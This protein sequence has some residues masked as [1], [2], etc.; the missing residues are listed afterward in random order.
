MIPTAITA[1]LGGPLDAEN[2]CGL[3]IKFLGG[4]SDLNR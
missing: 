1:E 2:V 3:T 4:A